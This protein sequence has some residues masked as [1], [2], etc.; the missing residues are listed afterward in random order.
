MSHVNRRLQVHLAMSSLICQR[1]TQRGMHTTRRVLQQ[2][3]QQ[4][5]SSGL[6]NMIRTEANGHITIQAVSNE[7]IDLSN[8]LRLRRS[9]IITPQQC[10]IWRVPSDISTWTEKTH[11]KAFELFSIVNPRPEVVLLGTGDKTKFVAPWIRQRF[12]AL[13]IQIDTFDTV[14]GFL[15]T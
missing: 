6:E 7:G 1:A 8:G 15:Y 12:H 11:S 2:Q 13:G 10:L 4:A 9:S 14:R 5:A 3:S